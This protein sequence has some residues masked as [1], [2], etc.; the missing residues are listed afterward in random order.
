[1]SFA[2]DLKDYDEAIRARRQQIAVLQLEIAQLE[3]GR[4]TRVWLEEQ[5]QGVVPSAALTDHQQGLLTGK[6]M[7]PVIAMRD[8]RPDEEADG[9]ASHVAK[10]GTRSKPRESPEA[11]E[12]RLERD[13]VRAQKKREAKKADGI[14]RAALMRRHKASGKPS[15]L[16]GWKDKVQEFLAEADEPATLSDIANY[17]GLPQGEEARKSLSNALYHLHA[18]GQIVRAP[19]S[20]TGPGRHAIYMLPP[21]SNGNGHASQR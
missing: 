3:D 14:E 12:K 7:R 20:P 17:F 2:T 10:Y 9:S 21:K 4:R 1:M 19:G 18:T 8:A 15:K 16:S 6:S 11:R 5:K 13:R